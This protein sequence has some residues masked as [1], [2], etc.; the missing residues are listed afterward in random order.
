[1]TAEQR[2]IVVGAGFA[3][4]GCAKELAKHD[5]VHVTLLDKHNYSQFMPLLYQVATSQ[6][7]ASDVGMNI[8]GEFHRHPNVDV[9]MAE[10][11]SVDTH[12]RSVTLDD[13]QV[14]VGDFLVLAGGSRANFFGI[15]GSEHT[16]PLYSLDD[17]ERLRSRILTLFEDADRDPELLDRGA[18]NFVVVGAGA[19][20]TEISGALAEMIRDVMP[21]EYRDL[22][23]SRAR[24]VLIDH[25]QFVLGPFSPKAHEYATKALQRDGVE[26]RLGTSVQEI[27]ADAVVLQGGES[28]STRCVIW[29]G[30]LQAAE[31]VS[32]SELPS[33]RGGRIDVLPDLTVADHP[34]VYAVGDIANAAAPDGSDFPQLGSVAL[35]EGRWAAK[36]I[37]ADIDGKPR[38]GF[39]YHDKGIMA[40]IGR[41]AAVAEVGEHRH[42]LHG[43]IA[44][45]AWLGVHVA[46]LSGVRHRVDAFVSWASDYFTKSRGP[47]VLD[48]SDVARIDWGEG[49]E[50][51]EP[52]A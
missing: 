43:P 34:G 29:G 49:E 38:T 21:S 16:F 9:K 4:I 42:E 28:I 7:A 50:K 31:L 24:M 22:A 37:L 15:S 23:V 3:G 13:G 32:R 35:Q 2:V 48:R 30:G 41:G 19:T 47:Q 25:G 8:R 39:H 14:L 27:R 52:D 51:G 12:S 17:A 44:F 11:V 10:V 46:L 6:L 1:M 45:A 5:D 40:M 36:N 20:G 26:L 33:G 18:L